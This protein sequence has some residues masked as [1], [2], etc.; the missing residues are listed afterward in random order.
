M[1]RGFLLRTRHPQASEPSGS[2]NTEPDLVHYNPF[3]GYNMNPFP[4]YMIGNAIPEMQMSESV[5]PDS[6]PPSSTSSPTTPDP[7]KPT[8]PQASE[9][10][11]SNSTQQTPY[12]DSPNFTTNS[13]FENLSEMWAASRENGTE[14]HGASLIDIDPVARSRFIQRMELYGDGRPWYEYI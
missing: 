1:K 5:P 4:D 2:T 3:P 9:P 13:W 14:W 12:F 11:G 6:T 8:E 10:P 7:N